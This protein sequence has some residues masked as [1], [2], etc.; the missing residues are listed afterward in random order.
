MTDIDIHHLGAAYALDAL[1]ERER[2]AFEAHYPACEVCR[3][4]VIDFRATV[5]HLAEASSVAPP[6]ALRAQVM[7]DISH[8]RQL[9]PLLPTAVIDMAERR[10]RRQ[11]WTGAAMAVAAAVVVIV[12]GTIVVGGDDQPAYAAKLETVLVQDDARFVTLATT[13]SDAGA[14]SVKVAWSDE[15]DS[16][17]LLADDLPAAPAGKAYELWLIGA[18]GPVP[19]NVLDRASD[20]Q[21]RKV[22]DISTAPQ[23]WGVTIEPD[24]GSPAPTG[25]ILYSATV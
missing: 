25:E 23:A 17:V 12:A 15:L 18:D 11:R 5:T 13:G 7:A 3:A 4:D 10:R 8:T 1:D 21:V 6:S 2:I 19:M 9:S 14:G 24:T 16:A 20:G 22:L